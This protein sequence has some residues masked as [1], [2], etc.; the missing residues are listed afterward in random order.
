MAK[1]K[2]QK[3]HTEDEKKQIVESICANYELG[4]T[5]E[6]CC[7][8]EGIDKGSFYNWLNN[9]QQLQQ[10]YQKTRNQIERNFKDR[11][12]QKALS[13]LEKM[14]EGYEYEEVHTEGKL[15]ETGKKDSE[16]KVIEKFKITKQTKTKKIVQPNPTLV[17]YALN[18]SNKFDDEKFVHATKTEITGQDGQPFAAVVNVIMQPASQK[19]IESESEMKKLNG[20]DE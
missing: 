3:K 20:I 6:S 14:V 16:G 17:M 10:I 9:S 2:G 13:S 15:V 4:N 11:L 7:E 1:G 5:I 12:R 18:N 19:P 8:N